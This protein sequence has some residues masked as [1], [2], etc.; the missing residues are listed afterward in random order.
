MKELDL[1][2]SQLSF[3]EL[4]M[5]DGGGSELT[6]WFTQ[7]AGGASVGAYFGAIGG[8]GGALVGGAIGASVGTMSYAVGF[9]ADK[10]MLK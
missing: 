10:G 3:E 9:I 1:N 4:E 7:V 8:L 5:I 2:M 6:N